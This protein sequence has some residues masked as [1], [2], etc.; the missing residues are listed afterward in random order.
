[1]IKWGIHNPNKISILNEGKTTNWYAPKSVTGIGLK[2]T[3]K[4]KY[5]N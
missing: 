3:V 2:L 1:M 4:S 5:G